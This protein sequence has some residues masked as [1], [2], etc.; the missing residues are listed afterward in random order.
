MGKIPQSEG[1]I[2]AYSNIIY[3]SGA[4]VCKISNIVLLV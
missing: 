1:G 4:N 3:T 2:M